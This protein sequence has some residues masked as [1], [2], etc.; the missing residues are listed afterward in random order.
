MASLE[1]GIRQ[2]D[3]RTMWQHEALDFTPWLAR[4]LD[5]LGVELD[6]K[7]ELVQQ[8]KPVGPLFLDILARVAGT[9][10]MVAIENQLEWTDISHLGQL[11]TYA[12][13]CDAHVAIWVAPEF[14]YEYARALDR[15]NEWTRD[16]ISFYG[17]KVEVVK[18]TGDS[19][20]KPRFRKVVFPGG[21]NKD[22][23][24]EAGATMS[25]RAQQY[26]DFFQP[27]IA[28]LILMDFA[29]KA[30]HHFDYRGRFFPSRLNRG[31]G[32]A[33]S[34]EGKNDAWVTLHVRTDDVGLTNR[35]FDELKACREDIESSIGPGP[36]WHW[37]RW[38]RFTFSSINIRKDGSIDNPHGRLEE[39]RAWM[40]DLLPKFKEVFDRR[41][42]DILKGAPFQA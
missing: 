16:G 11:L 18:G 29:D 6:M 2:L 20:P 40:M 42:D 32:Y 28:E 35:I 26:H 15:L 36:E 27:L 9:G 30:I 12:T 10:A 25:P 22:I 19:C 4:N 37:N 33:A 39:T 34:L 13:G 41:L 31:V 23:T 24:Q 17:V 7:L 5:L 8:E 1:E 21:W 14:R 38:D 3:V